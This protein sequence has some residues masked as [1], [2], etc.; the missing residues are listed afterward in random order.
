MTMDSRDIQIH[1]H[2][3]KCTLPSWCIYIGYVLCLLLS[4]F[5]VI[6]VVLY[7]FRFGYDESIKW[8]LAFLLSLCMSVLVIEPIKVSLMI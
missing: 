6:M 5:S 2:K 7:C 8:L 3:T 4:V 1:D